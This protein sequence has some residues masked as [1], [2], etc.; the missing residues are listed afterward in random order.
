MISEKIKKQIAVLT[1]GCNRFGGLP[2]KWKF[3]DQC[4][5][6]DNTAARK[7]IFWWLYTVFQLIYGTYRIYQL[8]HIGPRLEIIFQTRL[9]EFAHLLAIGCLGV[10]WTSLIFQ[11]KDN[12]SYA[13]A[14]LHSSGKLGKMKKKFF[15][16]L[17][18]M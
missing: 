16:K 1:N 18:Y 9:I 10:L 11:T 5:I 12:I 2:F 8:K 14:V 15:T 7:T 6:I 17:V 13:N 3:R 4:L